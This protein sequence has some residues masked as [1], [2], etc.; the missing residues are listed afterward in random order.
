VPEHTSDLGGSRETTNGPEPTFDLTARLAGMPRTTPSS[1][2][3]GQRSAPAQPATAASEPAPSIE[4]APV[5]ALATAGM[6]DDSAVAPAAPVANAAV[7]AVTGRIGRLVR[8]SASDLWPTVAAL[9]TWMADDP[10]LLGETIGMELHDASTGGSP[11]RV[12]A[13]TAD[14]SSIS[15]VCELAST[16]DEGLSAVLEIA[17]LGTADTVVWVAGIARP[18]HLASLSWLNRR[19][20]ARFL[21]VTV[22][23]VRI[24]SSDAA[25]LFDIAVRPSRAG[26]AGSAGTATAAAERRRAE[27]HEPAD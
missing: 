19:G 4:P 5:P 9:A 17:S 10:S 12:A 25:A 20:D 3:F 13:K 15:V 24:G 23:G 22:S 2:L 18:S 7:S 26:D 21:L 16:T 11:N 27:D 8:V 14:G 1:S 6:A